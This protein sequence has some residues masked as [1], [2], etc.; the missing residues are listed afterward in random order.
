MNQKGEMNLVFVLMVAGLSGVMILC[1]LS[2]QKSFRLLEKRTELFLCAK[3]TEG[4]IHQFMKFM[5][6]TNWAIK[7]V[8]KAKLIMMFI[9]GLQGGALKAEKAKQTLIY[10]QNT[11]LIPYLKKMAEMKSRNCPMDPRIFITP[12]HLAGF[13]F[14][15]SADSTAQLRSSKWTYHY[16]SFPYS[17][18]T[19][20]DANNFEAIN[21]RLKRI[22][23]EN[24][25]RLSS[26]LSS[27]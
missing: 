8:E 23:R 6:R 15:R 22:S 12:F 2:L 24:A 11:S 20:W 14:Q 18:S 1:A 10:I 21:P 17:L 13:G 4:E 26:I 25:A 7:N 5:G 9:P 3:E 19:D 27:Y 16:V